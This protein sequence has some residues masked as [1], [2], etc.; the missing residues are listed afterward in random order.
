MKGEC[1]CHLE[2]TLQYMEEAVF[3]KEASYA[4]KRKTPISLV[5]VTFINQHNGYGK[6]NE[7]YTFREY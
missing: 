6:P 5:D 1:T 4:I 2:D 3:H 7:L